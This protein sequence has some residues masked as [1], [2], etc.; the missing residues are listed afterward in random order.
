MGFKCQH[1]LNVA[2]GT[3]KWQSFYE[4]EKPC[5]IGAASALCEQIEL[6]DDYKLL[7]WVLEWQMMII[8]V[9]QLDCLKT[10]SL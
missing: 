10:K 6:C 9:I 5:I 1:L 3:R 8:E 7:F 2:T 4:R